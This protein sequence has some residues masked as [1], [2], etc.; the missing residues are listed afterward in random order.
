[1]PKSTIDKEHKQNIEGGVVKKSSQRREFKKRVKGMLQKKIKE[2][3][4]THLNKITMSPPFFDDTMKVHH[5]LMTSVYLT[6]YEKNIFEHFYNKDVVQRMTS[7]SLFYDIHVNVK[8]NFVIDVEHIFKYVDDYYEH[9]LK[10]SDVTSDLKIISHQSDFKNIIF[11]NDTLLQKKVQ[12]LNQIIYC[13]NTI[14]FEYLNSKKNIV[15][16][17]DKEM[18]T[19]LCKILE[20]TTGNAYDVNDYPFLLCLHNVM[21]DFCKKYDVIGQGNTTLKDEWGKVFSAFEKNEN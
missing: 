7:L 10:T 4:F 11:N 16:E 12:M 15:D 13:F 2:K 8:R 6:T 21:V 20:K 14:F 5:L 18:K 1:M 17:H 3:N 19:T 9:T